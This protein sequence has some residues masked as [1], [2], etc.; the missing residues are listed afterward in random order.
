MLS[1]RRLAFTLLILISQLLLLALA[2]AW[3]IQ[4]LVIYHNGSVRFVEYNR[5][6]LLLEIVM[7][8]IILIF[9]LVVFS[10]QIKRMGEKRKDDQRSIHKSG[11]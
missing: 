7:V 5:G 9:A 2:I 1:G 3:L 4:M 11:S 6:I 10:L 8:I